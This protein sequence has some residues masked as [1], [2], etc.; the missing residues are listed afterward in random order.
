M[1]KK[2]NIF[3][4]AAGLGERLRPITDQMPK[5]LL[6]VL[7]KP[8]LQYVIDNVS[9]LPFSKIGINLHHKKEAIE[10]WV[11]KSPLNEK[12]ELFHEE[13]ILGTG[14]ALKNAEDLLGERTFLVHN[15]DILSDINLEE[16][17]EHH[18]SS[19]NL[20]TLAVHDCP[21]FNSLVVDEK[22]F[23][24]DIEKIRESPLQDEKR[25]AFTGIAVYEPEFLKYL[26]AGTSSV[27]AA[28]LEAIRAGDKIGT[29]NVSGCYWSDIGTPSAYASAVFY[30]LK[31]DGESIYIHPSIGK[32]ENVDFRGYV[33]IERECVLDSG[34]M[35]KNCIMLPGSSAGAVPLLENCIIGRN[36]HIDLNKTELSGLSDDSGR[37]LIG[38]GGSDRKYYRINKGDKS[39]VLMQCKKHDPDFERHIEYTKFFIKHSVPVPV[40]IEVRYDERQAEFEDAGDVSLYNYLKCPRGENEVK[41][42]YKLIIDA[43]VLIHT[44]AADHIGECPLLQERVFDYDHF[45]WETG[46]FLERFAGGVEKIKTADHTGLEK[47]FHRLALEADAF[48]KTLIHRDFQSQNIMIMRELGIR[49]IDFQ[50]ARTGPPAYDI[51]SILWDPYYRLEDSTREGL[52]N[53]YMERMKARAGERFD[54]NNFLESLKICRLQRHMQ[55]LGAY[56]F[57][58]LAKGK[59][60]FLKYVPE[61]LR[62]LKE[63]IVPVK[64]EYPELCK[65]IMKLENV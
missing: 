36:I 29:L 64:D 54:E 52:V 3:I 53:Y 10:E 13:T 49:L 2:F 16:L 61:G 5:P 43:I 55:A 22:G 62:L 20:V 48:P 46:Y 26:P 19:G 41:D 12:I 8:A 65:L 40:L 63:D 38:T 34:A 44:A 50:G 35:L 57:L 42:I 25:S 21:E 1:G 6:P 28:W 4:L 18:F 39:L 45:R 17:L 23:L 37:Q 33:V 30:A 15:S 56:G 27:V 60:Y 14:G 24:K 31:T 58:S 51:S 7:G 11:S 47:E 9:S 59:K 32:C